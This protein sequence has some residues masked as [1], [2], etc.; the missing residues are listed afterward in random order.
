MSTAS[1]L[2]YDQAQINF[3]LFKV[4]L[5]RKRYNLATNS[6]Q[7]DLIKTDKS[8]ERKRECSQCLLHGLNDS[9]FKMY[10]S[11]ENVAIE[12][13]LARKRWRETSYFLQQVFEN[14]EASSEKTSSKK[15]YKI[16]SLG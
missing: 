13:T 1:M 15:Y 16:Q 6:K 3:V 5:D 4:R 2:A 12:Q 8:G 7:L 10:S 9:R 11:R 14:H